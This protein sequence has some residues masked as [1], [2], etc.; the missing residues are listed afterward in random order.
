MLALEHVTKTY[1]PGTV[2]ELTL[3]TDFNLSVDEGQFLSVV[4][5]NGSVLGKNGNWLLSPPS[6]SVMILS[7]SDHPPITW[8]QNRFGP[9]NH[10]RSRPSPPRRITPR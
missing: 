1:N 8:V 7:P 2:R 9:V 5:S 3:L 10:L 4:G 6:Q